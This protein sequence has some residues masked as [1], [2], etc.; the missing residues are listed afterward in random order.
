MGVGWCVEHE[1]LYGEGIIHDKAEN[2][3][4]NDDAIYYMEG[5][6]PVYCAWVHL[7]IL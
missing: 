6:I 5:M 3:G 2:A 1:M 7:A 4:R